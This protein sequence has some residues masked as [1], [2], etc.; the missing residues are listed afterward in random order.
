MAGLT[1]ARAAGHTPSM[2]TAP[3]LPETLT[4]LLAQDS[5]YAFEYGPGFANHAAMALPALAH[6]G[7]SEERLRD[8]AAGCQADLEP[9]PSAPQGLE[10]SEATWRIALGNPEREAALRAFF[11]QQAARSGAPVQVR[12]YLPG[13]LGGVGAAAFHGLLRVAYAL[14]AERAHAHGAVAMGLG[15]AYLATAAMDL[16]PGLQDGPEMPLP[17]LARRLQESPTL[18]RRP[19]DPAALL[20]AQMQVHSRRGGFDALVGR[21]AWSPTV[22]AELAYFAA[23]AHAS[24]NNI[25]S[26]HMLTGVHALRLVWP[27]VGPPAFALERS[28]RALVALYLASGAPPDDATL[29]PAEAGWPALRAMACQ[30][31]DV[32]VIKLVYSCWQESLCH[33]QDA[34]YRALAWRSL[35]GP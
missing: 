4:A 10:L 5:A 25:G 14:E 1:G 31:N 27:W 30:S 16:G 33:G 7:A 2:Q 6:L 29:E 13:L 15:L 22:L 17:E 3:A 23:A 19:P 8:F 11:A 21:P 32:H 28:W 24:A 12:K 26:L 18:A 35:Q 34:E 9:A 20:T